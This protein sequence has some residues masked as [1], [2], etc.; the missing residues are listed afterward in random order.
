MALCKACYCLWFL[1]AS[2]GTFLRH[3]LCIGTAP[4]ESLTRLMWI[5]NSWKYSRKLQWEFLG[6]E[7]WVVLFECYRKKRRLS[8]EIYHMVLPSILVMLQFLSFPI[9]S[10]L[11]LLH[12]LAHQWWDFLAHV[13]YPN[14]LLCYL[15]FF[16]LNYSFVISGSVSFKVSQITLIH[17]QC[18]FLV[19]TSTSP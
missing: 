9:A 19:C 16:P 12:F 1:L 7:I 5:R 6:T 15:V 14:F 8:F 10:N 3:E 2:F 13:F 18:S 11:S 17:Q 4:E